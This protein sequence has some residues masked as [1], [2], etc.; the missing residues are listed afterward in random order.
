[1]PTKYL[2]AMASRTVWRSRTNYTL[3]AVFA[4]LALVT[5]GW[6]L[7]FLALLAFGDE[8]ALPP[9]GRTPDVPTGA[10]VI[11]ESTQ[12]GSGGCWRLV[13]VEPPAG[14]S[15]EDLARAM[16][17]AEE[18][19]EPPTLLDPGFVNVGADPREGLLVIH[20]GYR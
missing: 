11:E 6:T 13:T 17:L 7:W 3:I 20:I 15:P 8:G 5:V 10:R 9:S 19:S 14:Q 2:D 4:A 1:M 12:C 18:R 16:G